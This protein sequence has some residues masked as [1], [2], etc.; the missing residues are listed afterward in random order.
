MRQGS[1]V[2]WS[3][4]WEMIYQWAVVVSYTCRNNMVSINMVPGLTWVF[5]NGNSKDS[6][7]QL[8]SYQKTF[9]ATWNPDQGPFFPIVILNES[10][11]VA[12]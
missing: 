11:W 4:F 10:K 2:V 3:D 6:S 1:P 7:I 8:G 5:S 12:K 9:I